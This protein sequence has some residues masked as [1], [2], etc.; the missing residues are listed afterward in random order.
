MSSLKIEAIDWFGDG[1]AQNLDELTFGSL[2]IESSQGIVTEVSDSIAKAT[3]TKIHVP[4]NQFAEW[5]LVHWWRLFWE[6]KPKR[7]TSSWRRA[8]N[9]AAISGAYAWPALE[10]SSD[11]EFVSLKLDREPTADVAAIRYLNTIT[12]ELPAMEFRKSVDRFLD[13]IDAR[14][15]TVPSVGNP[16]RDLRAEIQLEQQ[17]PEAA[18][19]CRF[20]ARAG[21]TTGDATDEWFAR[22][23]Q[24]ASDIGE[25]ATEDILA[26]NA[27]IAKLEESVSALKQSNRIVNF[28]VLQAIAVQNASEL[29]WQ[30]GV[31]AATSM[32]SELGLNSGPIANGAFKE[33]LGVVLPLSADNVMPGMVG[34]YRL[35]AHSNQARVLVRSPRLQSQRFYLARLLGIGAG[36][37]NHATD[38]MLPITDAGTALQKFTRA[39]AQEF[40]CPWDELKSFIEEEGTSDDSIARA[41]DHYDVS[42]RLI[43]TALVNHHMMPRDRLD[44]RD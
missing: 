33:L 20:E 42:E 23:E 1:S 31:R 17:D 6:P 29:P 26:E 41:A 5:L 39:F 28:P 9:M 18:R 14:I 2:C 15:A 44:T 40:L 30:R 16:V 13:Q 36:T 3:R 21:M 8:H 11:G 25:R 10:V 34:A 12:V 22:V 27:D 37:L 7:L 32:R 4:M 35:G 19:R 38:V 43:E 24:L